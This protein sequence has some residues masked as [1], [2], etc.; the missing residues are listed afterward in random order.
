MTPAKLDSRRTVQ[1]QII[2]Y[3]LADFVSSLEDL[4]HHVVTMAACRLPKRRV[5]ELGLIALVRI[6]VI[7][8]FGRPDLANSLASCTVR[9]PRLEGGC[10][11]VPSACV[12]ATTRIASQSIHAVLP[13]QHR[14]ASAQS[15][16]L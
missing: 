8:N 10:G 1:P 5:P 3:G 12:A 13:Q 7:N 15:S 9:M 11:F 2:K 4:L 16:R 6:D 14:T